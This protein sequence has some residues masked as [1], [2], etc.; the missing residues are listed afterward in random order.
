ME[1]PTTASTLIHAATLVTAG[2]Y[3][4]SKLAASSIN[5][6]YLL[7]FGLLTAVMASFLAF[8]QID[9][10]RALA[11][12]TSA[13]MGFLCFSFVLPGLVGYHLFSHAVFKASLFLIVGAYLH[14]NM[15]QTRDNRVGQI[16]DPKLSKYL[17]AVM[18]ICLVALPASLGG[19]SKESMLS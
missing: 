10:K 5:G 6:T 3:L 2:V 4:L 9:L 11:Y 13:Q 7:I 19:S 12:S 8:S 18:A 17:I 16:I 1:G 14:N 15:E